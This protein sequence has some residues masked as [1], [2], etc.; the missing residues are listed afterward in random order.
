MITSCGIYGL[1][2]SLGHVCVI[3]ENRYEIVWCRPK[4]R[5]ANTHCLQIG[6]KLRFV[7]DY[8]LCGSNIYVYIYTYMDS[9]NFSFLCVCF[10]LCVE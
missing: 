8:T 3:F 4:P 1:R 2:T 6:F 10:K 7:F 5:L 9:V